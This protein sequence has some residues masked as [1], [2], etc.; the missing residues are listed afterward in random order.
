MSSSFI[1][2]LRYVFPPFQVSSLSLSWN[3][4]MDVFEHYTQFYP[5]NISYLIRLAWAKYY[6]WEITNIR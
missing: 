6:I 4:Q 1:V 5:I 2:T 3:S